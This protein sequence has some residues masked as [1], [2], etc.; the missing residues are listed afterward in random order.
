VRRPALERNP[1]LPGYFADPSLFHADGRFWITSTTDWYGWEAG[2]FVAWRSDDLVSW[3]FRGLI[4]P[5]VAGQRN[6]AP[7]TMVHRGGRYHLFFSKHVQIHVAVSDSPEGPFRDALDG[8]PLIPQGF[9]RDTQSI[10]SEVLVDEDGQAYLYWG[11]GPT[12]VVKLRGDLLALEGEPVRIPTNEKFGYVEGPFPFRRGGKYYL[13]GA[14]SGYHDYHIIYGIADSPMGPFAFPDT[15]PITLVDWEEGVWG[16]GHGSVFQRPGTDEWYLCYLRDFPREVVSPIPRQVAVDRMEFYPDGRIQPVRL[17]RRGVDP[18]GG[19]GAEGSNL[20]MGA[21]ATA[22]SSG[23]GLYGERGPESAADGSFA[24]RW[25]AASDA[26]G[27]WWRVDLGGE[28]DIRS[29]EVFPEFPTK[30]YVYRVE[31]S[32]DGVT[33]DAYASRGA[34]EVPG[35][36]H[37]HTRVA[38]ARY[39]RLVFQE[40]RPQGTLP[41]LWEVRVQG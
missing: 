39:L 7:S 30:A 24:T 15:N 41:A 35:S 33:W 37:V 26:P 17:S 4:Y 38:R 9:R 2:P 5:E 21:E 16:P 27:A 22:S 28:R 1:V 14:A 23:G 3:S 8:K 36:P 31:T 32:R 34:D 13:T 40:T 6:W 10:D 12:Y 20:A 19:Q 18:V 25:V 11:G 29:C